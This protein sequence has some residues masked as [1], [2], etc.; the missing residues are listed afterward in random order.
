[1]K[2]VVTGSTGA[3]LSD[4]ECHILFVR[5]PGRYIGGPTMAYTTLLDTET[6]ARHVA[7]PSFAVVDCRFR[8]DD[9]GW[10]ERVYAS[11]HIAGAVYAHLDRDLS[12][13]RTGTNGRHPLPDPS[14]LERSLSAMGIDGHVQV[15]AYDQDS[16]M[17]ASRL[18][19][20]L[21]WLGHERVAV[22]DG[23]FAKWLAEHRPVR[24]GVEVR[25]GRRFSG[26]PRPRDVAPL[27]DVLER[28]NRPDWRLVDARAPERYR[29]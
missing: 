12:G 13:P 3:G 19:W 16:G 23:G 22:L 27:S 9:P 21:R 8:L 2:S 10:G 5:P 15:V 25:P 24:S 7:D 17:F 28:F 18:W 14:A 29:G 11:G 6:L 20:L 1:M 4:M 26:A